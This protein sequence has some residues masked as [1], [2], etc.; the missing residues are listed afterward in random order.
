MVPCAASGYSPASVWFRRSRCCATV[1]LCLLPA[2]YCRPDEPRLHWA[3]PAWWRQ[4]LHALVRR[5][6]QAPHHASAPLFQRLAT[7]L[8]APPSLDKLAHDSAL[9]K[10]TVIRAVKQD[11]GLTPASL[12]NMARIEYA[13]NAFTR[14]GPHYC[15]C[16]L[17]RLALP[18]RAISIKPFVSYTAATPRQYAH[19]RSISDNK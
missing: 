3:T 17:I 6:P 9:R 4:L 12:I 5:Q 11:T 14:R 16:R 2:D 13:E 18:I 8:P 1:L 15:R 19:S 10:E 7:D